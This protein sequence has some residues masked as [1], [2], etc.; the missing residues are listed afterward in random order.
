[1]RPTILRTAQVDG[2]TVR[3]RTTP[4][5]S[6]PVGSERPP[7]VLVHGLGMTHRYLDRLRA[8]LASDAVVHSIDLPGY[9]S[10]P[11]PALQL[12]VEDHAAL[13]VGALA[14]LGV[15]RCILVGH[16]MGVQFVTEVALQAPALAARLVLIGPVVDRMRRTVLQQALS[17][18]HDTLRESPSANLLVAGDYLRTGVR[19]YLR[20]LS[21][22]MRYPLELGVQRVECPVLV[23]RGGRDPVAP[24]RW[25]LELAER[26]R[27]GILV[28]I[29]G[30]PHVVQHSAPDRVA[31]EITAFSRR[32]LPGDG[33]FLSQASD[34]SRG[35]LEY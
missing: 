20:Q 34:G 22:M 5:P 31:A 6:V 21:P 24:R 17:L 2:F 26:A 16:S 27:D 15:P 10:D 8:E 28:E 23:I 1:M 4:G 19:W 14:G 29:P 30:Q 3:I 13:I 9:G 32:P 35:K 33:A 18:G 7:Y 11:R 12:G 25:G